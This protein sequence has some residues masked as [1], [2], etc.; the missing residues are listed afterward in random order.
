MVCWAIQA[1]DSCTRKGTFRRLRK[2][3]AQRIGCIAKNLQSDDWLFV[4]QG[5]DECGR[6]HE[7]ETQAHL[8]TH[9]EARN[10]FRSTVSQLVATGV[11]VFP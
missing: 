8:P 5:R 2:V 10:A 9:E 1:L 7:I 11:K 6:F 4:V 3:T